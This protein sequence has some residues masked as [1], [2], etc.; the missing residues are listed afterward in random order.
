[1]SHSSWQYEPEDLG[2]RVAAGL[3]GHLT[4]IV[5]VPPDDGDWQLVAVDPAPDTDISS[6][7]Q[8]T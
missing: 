4:W 7:E 6:N 8:E 3:A 2:L 5:V 1:M